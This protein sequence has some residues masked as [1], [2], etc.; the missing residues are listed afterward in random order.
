MGLQSLPRVWG[1]G[2]VSKCL[3]VE[4]WKVAPRLVKNGSSKRAKEE[5]LRQAKALA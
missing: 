1:A 2:G 3:I 4:T 5:L